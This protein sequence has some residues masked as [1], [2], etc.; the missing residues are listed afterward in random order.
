MQKFT[1]ALVVGLMIMGLFVCGLPAAS[2]AQATAPKAAPKPALA[3]S[4]E[5]LA[6]WNDLGRRLVDMAEDFPEDKYDFKTTPAQRTFAENLLH[7]VSDGLRE[8]SAIKGSQVG[9]PVD[10]F[11]DLTREQYK[12]KADV[13]KVLKQLVADGA[14]V[15]KAQS[16]AGLNKETANPYDGSLQHAWYA[17]AGT[18]EH[19]GEH[20]GQLVVYYRV[21]GLVPP[22]SRPKK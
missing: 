11:K 8:V 3:P 9:P 7:V 15:I 18:L 2:L 10:K 22:E 6:A 1:S 21:A 17:W 5:I 13:V 12:T 4:E 16:D 19:E 14:A 20:Y